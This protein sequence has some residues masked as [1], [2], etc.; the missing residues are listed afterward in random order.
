MTVPPCPLVLARRTHG[1]LT[2]ARLHA[3]HYPCVCQARHFRL[4]LAN[5]P[6]H[7]QQQSSFCSV[8]NTC[9]PPPPLSAR[10]IHP[11]NTPPSPLAARPIAL[12]HALPHNTASPRLAAD[13]PA[14][15]PTCMGRHLPA[16]SLTPQYSSPPLHPH[17]NHTSPSL[18]THPHSHGTACL[19]LATAQLLMQDYGYNTAD[20]L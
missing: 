19:V 16:C 6:R 1:V 7:H 20:L 14:A 2:A 13:H 4:P 18:P 5:L 12:L 11:D 10:P 15:P 9:T 3:T 17:N 8:S